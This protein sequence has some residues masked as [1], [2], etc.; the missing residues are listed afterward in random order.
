MTNQGC[1]GDKSFSSSE[2]ASPDPWSTVECT[3]LTGH[4]W[5]CVQ[6]VHIHSLLCAFQTVKIKVGVACS[7]E[8]VLCT[9]LE[10]WHAQYGGHG[11]YSVGASGGGFQ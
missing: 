6:I 7:V 8:A 4:C 5:F 9:L 10:L 2:H 3:V 11:S 1:L